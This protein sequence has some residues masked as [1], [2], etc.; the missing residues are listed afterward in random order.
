MQ[1]WTM[2]EEEI[3][4]AAVDELAMRVLD[5]AR[6]NDEWNYRTWLLR[7]RTEARYSEEVLLALSTAWGWLQS[8]GL[9]A[10]DINQ[11]AVEAFKITRQGHDALERGLAYLRATQRLDLPLHPTLET[12]VRPQFL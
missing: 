7:A 9:I 10:L 1:D 12:K 2:T 4:A 8:R 6:A 11:G 5:D 3:L